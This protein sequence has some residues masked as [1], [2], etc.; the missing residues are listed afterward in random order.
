MILVFAFLVYNFLLVPLC[1]MWL[2]KQICRGQQIHYISPPALVLE[3]E[4]RISFYKRGNRYNVTLRSL[5]AAIVALGNPVYITH[6]E[7]VY[8]F[9]P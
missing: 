5:R 3:D 2:F 9:M 8:I 6:S 7:C 4:N 1:V